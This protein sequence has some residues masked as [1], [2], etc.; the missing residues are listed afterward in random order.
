[1]DNDDLMRQA[2]RAFLSFRV[3]S[4]QIRLII[5]NEGSEE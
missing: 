5:L 4:N 3:A 1:V 2:A